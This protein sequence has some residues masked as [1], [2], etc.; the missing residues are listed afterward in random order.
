M[1]QVQTAESE[2]GTSSLK[3]GKPLPS[4]FLG[5]FELCERKCML[6]DLF[7]VWIIATT[8]ALE[9]EH[10]PVKPA[11][12]PSEGIKKPPVAILY[13]ANHHYFNV[14]SQPT[15]PGPSRLKCIEIRSTY[16][17]GVLCALRCG[18]QGVTMRN[19]Q[20]ESTKAGLKEFEPIAKKRL[21]AGENHR[22][23]IIRVSDEDE[24]LQPNIAKIL[25]TDTHIW[26][27]NK[28]QSLLRCLRQ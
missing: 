12:E 14:C 26:S 23:K 7:L 21:R 8:I 22:R 20:R 10:V 28:H 25:V 3:Q 2:R 4:E 6:G 16:W 9:G 15:D 24:I 27:V 18:G 13:P 17:D 5:L 1:L 19:F 11:T